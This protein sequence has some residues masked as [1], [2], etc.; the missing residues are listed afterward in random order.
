MVVLDQDRV[1][2]AEPVVD[3]AAAAHGELLQRPEPGR[4]L[5]GIDD[6]RVG[7]LHRCHIGRGQGGDAGQTAQQV[8]SRALGA[9][10][11]PGVAAHPGD[12]IPGLDPVSVGHPRLELGAGIQGGEGQTGTGQAR[13]PTW[14]PGGQDRGQ[15][16]LRRDQRGRQVPAAAQ[17]LG[18]RLF[19]DGSDQKVGQGQHGALSLGL[20]ARI[21]RRSGLPNPIGS[22]YASHRSPYPDSRCGSGP[23]GFPVAPGPR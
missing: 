6:H 18:Q 5:A 15:G 1:I 4:G 12:H 2:E 11:R 8:Q 16:L 14:T 22:A 10:N 23:R 19:H 7:A 17:I 9:Q 21:R 20:A 3:P 13:H